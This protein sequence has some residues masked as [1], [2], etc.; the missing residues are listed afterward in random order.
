MW[1]W[2]WPW[3]IG[4]MQPQAK[5]Y[6]WRPEDRRD[7]KWILLHIC[8]SEG[9]QPYQYLDASIVLILYSGLQNC[10]RINLCGFK[11]LSLKIWNDSPLSMWKQTLN[12]RFQNFLITKCMFNLPL[13]FPNWAFQWEASPIIHYHI[14]SKDH[15]HFLLVCWKFIP[16]PSLP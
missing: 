8:P 5:E 16:C 10:K 7:K 15:G 1:R 2:C 9:V 11:S 4:L 3:K 14:T 6:Q 12:P 13:P